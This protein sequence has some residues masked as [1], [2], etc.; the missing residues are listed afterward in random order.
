MKEQIAQLLK[1]VG[2]H[3]APGEDR[4]IAAVTLRRKL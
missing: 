4:Y 2:N 3:S 1:V